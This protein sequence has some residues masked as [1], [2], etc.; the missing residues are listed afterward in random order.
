MVKF[1]C[2]LSEVQ[3]LHHEH[4]CKG[5]M[6]TWKFHVDLQVICMWNFCVSE[7]QKC[8]CSI[9]HGDFKRNA[10]KAS[11]TLNWT[12]LSCNLLTE[13]M[14][15]WQSVTQNDDAV[16]CKIFLLHM[17][18]HQSPWV[19]PHSKMPSFPN[20]G[21]QSNGSYFGIIPGCVGDVFFG[22]GIICENDSSLAAKQ[23]MMSSTNSPECQELLWDKVCSPCL[24]LVAQQR[25]FKLCFVAWWLCFKHVSNMWKG[26][27]TWFLSRQIGVTTNFGLAWILAKIHTMLS[28]IKWKILE[29]PIPTLQDGSLQEA[30]PI[31]LTN[32]KEMQLCLRVCNKSLTHSWSKLGDMFPEEFDP[33]KKTGMCSQSKNPW[34]AWQSTQPHATKTWTPFFRPLV[35]L[36]LCQGDQC[37]DDVKDVDEQFWIGALMTVLTAFN[38]V[39][40]HPIRNLW[41]ITGWGDFAPAVSFFFLLLSLSSAKISTTCWLNEASWGSSTDQDCLVSCLVGTFAWTASV[42]M[43]SAA[44]VSNHHP[45]QSF[46]SSLSC[47]V[48]HADCNSVKDEEASDEHH[49]LQQDCFKHNEQLN[50]KAIK[51]IQR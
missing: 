5:F 6:T 45:L 16:N 46:S 23:W 9:S 3:H 13:P 14:C 39:L 7:F 11:S 12:P 22:R 50:Q 42:V 33:Q 34:A 27:Q 32:T 35:H 38:D 24:M 19:F 44:G 31:V 49:Q 8:V 51:L 47:S 41:N 48:A 30:T 37:I 10:D 43:H 4:D 36:G 17:W 40:D 29:M 1:W 2:G 20:P 21:L 28:V 18:H 15:V 26:H 25:S